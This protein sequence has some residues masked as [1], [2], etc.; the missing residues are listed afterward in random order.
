MHPAARLH[1][2]QSH[3]WK[4]EWVCAQPLCCVMNQESPCQLFKLHIH[5]KLKKNWWI[6]LVKSST[7]RAG[8]QAW[9]RF[10]S[11]QWSLN[12]RHSL[13]HKVVGLQILAPHLLPLSRAFADT[14][15]SSPHL[16]QSLPCHTSMLLQHSERKRA[17]AARDNCLCFLTKSWW[18]GGPNCGV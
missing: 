14:L 2:V 12:H 7:L 18:F 6:T 11:C 8:S 3:P 4:S 1:S 17:V 9:D 10:P 15:R 13:M 5:P 16:Y